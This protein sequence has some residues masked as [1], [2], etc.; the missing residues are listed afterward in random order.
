[1]SSAG[2][3]MMKISNSTSD[4]FREQPTTS[5]TDLSHPSS[6]SADHGTSRK[7]SERTLQ[8]SRSSS[9]RV[10]GRKKL[11][12]HLSTPLVNVLEGKPVNEKLVVLQTYLLPNGRQRALVAHEVSKQL[13]PLGWMAW[14]QQNARG[15]GAREAQK[16]A[17]RERLADT[18][19]KCSCEHEKRMQTRPMRATA[20][21]NRVVECVVQA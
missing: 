15:V 20:P 21:T 8:G 6:A 7:H 11:A 13:E 2:W 4:E 5:T 14:P 19:A 10:V 17:Y 18:S 16:R 12:D 9:R 1:M 3:P